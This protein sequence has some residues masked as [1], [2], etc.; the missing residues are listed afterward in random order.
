MFEDLFPWHWWA[1]AAILVI[2]ELTVSGTFF[3]LFLAA[4]AAIVG[5]VAALAPGVSW[6]VQLFL[7]AALSIVSV[8]LWRACKP[9]ERPSEHPT[10]NRRGHQYV[11]RRFTLAEPVVDGVGKLTVAD[12]TWKIA[13]PDLPAGARVTVTGVVGTALRIEESAEER[14]GG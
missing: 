14:D 11:G 2:L 9:K 3:F 10:L 8:F 6:E 5:A 4:A 1:I 7:Y 12:T 13:G